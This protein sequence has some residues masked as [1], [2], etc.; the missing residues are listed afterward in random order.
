MALSRFMGQNLSW[1]RLLI[2]INSESLESS[3]SVVAKYGY[4]DYQLLRRGFHYQHGVFGHCSALGL[5]IAFVEFVRPI[6][7]PGIDLSRL[8]YT[9]LCFSLFSIQKNVGPRKAKWLM[10]VFISLV[11]LALTGMLTNLYVFFTAP[12]KAWILR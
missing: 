2:E 7:A 4:G 12:N 5:G 6:L 11:F 10:L 1:L 8:L 3:R 9:A